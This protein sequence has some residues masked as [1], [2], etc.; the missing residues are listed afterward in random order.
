MALSHADLWSEPRPSPILPDMH[1]TPDDIG[2]ATRV[3]GHSAHFRVPIRLPEGT[4]HLICGPGLFNVP[5]KSHQETI[6]T[7]LNA[8]VALLGDDDVIAG[9][10]RGDLQLSSL[11]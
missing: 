6:S 11:V 8:R 2:A 1:F 5:D 10:T 3:G 4:G 7:A 9:L